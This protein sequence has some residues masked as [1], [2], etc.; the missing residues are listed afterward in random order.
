MNSLAKILI[1]FLLTINISSLLI[2]GLDKSRSR[3][4]KRR[5][6][7]KSLFFLALF[8]GALGIYLGM[9]LFRHKTKKW[10]FA[11]I[12]PLLLALN[13]YLFFI[14]FQLTKLNF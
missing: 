13:L 14:L 7:E 8:G 11:W 5:I 9:F 1:G 3:T 10:Y 6:S 12:I 4:N 2:M